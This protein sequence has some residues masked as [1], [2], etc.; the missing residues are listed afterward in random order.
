MQWSCSQYLHKKPR[1]AKRLLRT[2]PQGWQESTCG[3]A[4]RGEWGRPDLRDSPVLSGTN[5][6]RRSGC[7]SCTLFY[8]S[9]HFEGYS[10]VPGRH[11]FL[12]LHGIA[13]AFGLNA[14]LA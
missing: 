13:E 5:E 8:P 6:A 11:T 3:F 10:L 7:L 4:D 14:E 1:T 9:R 12:I 2:F